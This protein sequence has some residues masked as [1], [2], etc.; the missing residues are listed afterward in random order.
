MK[1]KKKECMLHLARPKERN[2]LPESK[3]RTIKKDTSSHTFSLSPRN[4]LLLPD[5]NY[6][7]MCLTADLIFW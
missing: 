7:F 3:M 5:L 6:R 1:E 4:P 2:T